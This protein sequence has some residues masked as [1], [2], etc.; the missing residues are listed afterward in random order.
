M[1]SNRTFVPKL[2]SLYQVFVLGVMIDTS[3]E[4]KE[5][6]RSLQNKLF[7]TGVL[8]AIPFIVIAVI[9]TVIL[10]FNSGHNAIAFVNIVSL[11]SAI[12]ILFNKGIPLLSRKVI[13][14]FMIIVYATILMA[15]M[16]SF[17]LGCIYLFALSIFI[18][19]QFSSRLAYL[20][21]VINFLICAGF[22]LLLYYKP[23]QLPSLYET[24]I[25]NWLIYSTNFIIINL[26][27]VMSVRHLLSGLEKNMLKESFL[28]NELYI[29][30]I[31][32][33]KN[34]KL[35][36][37]SANQYKTLFFQSPLPKIIFDAENLQ[38]L[39]INEAAVDQYCYSE[40]E[41]LN[42]NLSEIFH[43]DCL[44]D[45]RSWIAMEQSE[46]KKNNHITKTVRK[47]GQL[48]HA[49]IRS[50]D[51][52]FEG[53]PAKLIIATDISQQ[54]FDTEILNQKN[55]KLKQIAYLQS[56][57]IRVPLAN[58]MGLSE[59]ILQDVKTSQEKELLHH[60]SSSI[61]ELDSVIR[62]IV[63]YTDDED[64]VGY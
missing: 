21:V 23:F 58:I 53:K 5:S 57:V 25:F 33:H 50:S 24:S 30:M 61:T 20:S 2:W 26:V 32:R 62:N 47:D 51:I 35:L 31:N 17:T 28:F 34:G 29:E 22:S 41:F 27:L 12:L 3:K 49:E 4:Q 54:I 44:S 55:E 38:I 15:F 64:A 37:E 42:T 46:S 8:Y 13:L 6:I 48:V 59:L 52:S 19:I 7:A 9:P 45:F 63:N 60:L 40:E 56:H 36:A 1:T 14:S 18:A 16:G 11:V 10:E 39:Q 43:P